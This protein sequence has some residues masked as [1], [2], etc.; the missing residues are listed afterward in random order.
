MERKDGYYRVKW[1]DGT[2]SIAYYTAIGSEKYRWQIIG[3]GD[4]LSDNNFEEI[5][6]T[7]INPNPYA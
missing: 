3:C 5:N 2:W 4:L 6:E 7:P 1:N